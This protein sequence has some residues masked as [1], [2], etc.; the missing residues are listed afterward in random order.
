MPIDI[1]FKLLD[2]LV[3]PIMTYECEIWGHDNF[4]LLEKLHLK[5]CKI[6]LEIKTS[7][8]GYIV[9]GELGR[10]PLRITIMKRMIGYWCTF[11]L[12]KQNRLINHLHRI[13]YNTDN[14]TNWSNK[15]KNILDAHGLSDIWIN[16]SFPSQN[17]A[18]INCGEACLEGG[19]RL[20]HIS[21]NTP[22][23]ISYFRK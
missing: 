7:T 2:T 22:G 17:M 3:L 6:T 23:D 20:S 10:Y 16:Q 19:V 9:Y 18:G 13:M 15:I 5:F 11:L 1:Q 8:L 12:S 14:S 21:Y 4:V